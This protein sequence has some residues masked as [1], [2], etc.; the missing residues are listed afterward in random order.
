M[1]YVSCNH[2]YVIYTRRN[3]IGRAKMLLMPS[4]YVYKNTIQN[5]FTHSHSLPFSPT[6]ANIKVYNQMHMSNDY[7]MIHRYINNTVSGNSF[8]FRD[9][10]FYMFKYFQTDIFTQWW[11][12]KLISRE[13]MLKA[14]CYYHEIYDISRSSYRCHIILHVKYITVHWKRITSYLQNITSKLQ[15][16][17]ISEN[18]YFTSKIHFLYQTPILL[19]QKHSLLYQTHY[20]TS[21]TL[22]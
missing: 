22:F 16:I 11:I 1:I 9:A 2:N 4:P 8:S 20:F 15:N 17:T 18:Y 19:Y 5:K 21:D 3:E 14:M 13:Y 12:S 6:P 10:N 7:I